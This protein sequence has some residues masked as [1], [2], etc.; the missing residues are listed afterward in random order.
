MIKRLILAGLGAMVILAGVASFAAF[1]AQWVNI[2]ARVEKEIEVACVD[3]A[4]HVVDCDFGVVFPENIHEKVIEVALS[5]SFYNQTGKSDVLYWALWEC[6]P[7][8]ETLPPGPGNPCREDIAHTD[9]D[10]VYDGIEGKWVHDNGELDGNIRDYVLVT[11]GPGCIEPYTGPSGGVGKL[12]GIGDGVIDRD[13]A[14]KCFYHLAFTPPA[15]EGHVNPLTDPLPGG[16]TV[17]CHEITSDPDPQNWDR[18][19]ELGDNFKI[20]VYAFSREV[21]P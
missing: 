20:Q 5:N 16:L 21:T 14:P 4:G 9:A 13:V 6:K 10:L 19:A 7:L 12:E 3:S 11:A 15:C 18:F 2:T 8:D 17:D 1:T